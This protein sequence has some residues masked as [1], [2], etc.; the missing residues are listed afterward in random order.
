MFLNPSFLL[1]GPMKAL[2]QRLLETCSLEVL[3][4]WPPSV[5]PGHFVSWEAQY[6]ITLLLYSHGK[7]LHLFLYINSSWTGPPLPMGSRAHPTVWKMA[8]SVLR[9]TLNAPRIQLVSS[10]SGSSWYHRRHHHHLLLLQWDRWLSFLLICPLAPLSRRHLL[11]PAPF[12]GGLW[13]PSSLFLSSQP[14][15]SRAQEQALKAP[16]WHFLVQRALMTPLINTFQFPIWHSRPLLFG[17]KYSPVL[18]SPGLLYRPVLTQLGLILF[19]EYAPCFLSCPLLLFQMPPWIIR[20]I[21]FGCLDTD[22]H[23]DTHTR[24][25][26]C[27]YMH[28]IYMYACISCWSFQAPLTVWEGD[29]SCFSVEP[30]L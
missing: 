7:P 14:P 17:N 6:S 12:L 24:V 11:W 28:Y 3:L 25:R 22:R 20:T 21:S 23:T 26:V 10:P 4:S 13:Q 5:S 8:A 9:F 19:T 16:P 15:L 1:L 27:V 30:L 2:F 29:V 18:F